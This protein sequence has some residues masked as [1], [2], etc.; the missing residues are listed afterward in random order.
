MSTGFFQHI[1]TPVSVT[2]SGRGND[3]AILQACSLYDTML[4][5]SAELARRASE[6]MRTDSGIEAVLDEA[7][8]LKERLCS[9][10]GG[11]AQYAPGQGPRVAR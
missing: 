6:R 8:A 11:V 7:D 1:Y 3:A 4:S 5:W 9:L 2:T 10:R